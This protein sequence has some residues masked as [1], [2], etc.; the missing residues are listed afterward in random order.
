[1]YLYTYKYGL[2]LVSV[3]NVKKNTHTAL[4]LFTSIIHGRIRSKH[5]NSCNKSVLRVAPISVPKKAVIERTLQ[6][7][8]IA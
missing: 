2:V 1:M 5:P 3:R 8:S 4:S 6:D 7:F